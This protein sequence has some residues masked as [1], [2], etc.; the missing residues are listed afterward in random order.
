MRAAGAFS[1]KRWGEVCI[2]KGRR[3]AHRT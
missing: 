2:K 1:G 3:E